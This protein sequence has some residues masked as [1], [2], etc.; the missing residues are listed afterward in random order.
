[1][2]RQLNERMKKIQLAYE[3]DFVYAGRNPR[4]SQH[5][6]AAEDDRPLNTSLQIWHLNVPK[7]LNTA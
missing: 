3:F 4:P 2:E 5:P 1:M 7:Q 6:H